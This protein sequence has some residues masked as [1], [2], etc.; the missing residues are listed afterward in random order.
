MK[1]KKPKTKTTKP[2]KPTQTLSFI[3]GEKT[4]T[5]LVDVKRYTWLPRCGFVSVKLWTFEFYQKCE[6]RDLGLGTQQLVSQKKSEWNFPSEHLMLNLPDG[7]RMKTSPL[8]I[9]LTSEKGE[10]SRN[11]EAQRPVLQW[12]WKRMPVRGVG[13]MEMPSRCFWLMADGLPQVA[14]WSQFFGTAPPLL[15]PWDRA[16]N[17][18]SSSM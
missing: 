2:N 18:L 13:E 3:K 8:N 9:S 10:S 17:K 11:V 15:L 7:N 16:R 12:K 6:A 5:L 4:K 1:K 14:R